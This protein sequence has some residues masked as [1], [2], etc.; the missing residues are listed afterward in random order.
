M[1]HTPG[2]WKIDPSE[3]FPLAVIVDDEDGELDGVCICE[4]QGEFD[5]KSSATPEQMS[6]ARLIAAA[7]E[8]LEAC[9]YAL[10]QLEADGN[11]EL[12]CEDIRDAIRKAKGE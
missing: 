8:L 11:S 12:I 10:A 6:N 3:E 9:K 7:P 1:S 2:P 5:D 4:L